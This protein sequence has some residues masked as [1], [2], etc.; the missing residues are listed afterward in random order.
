MTAFGESVD[1]NPPIPGEGYRV[2]LRHGGLRDQDI[3]RA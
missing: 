1:L 3:Q 2:R